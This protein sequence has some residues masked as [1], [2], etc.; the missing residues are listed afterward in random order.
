VIR[1]Q[2]ADGVTNVPF[3]Q[4]DV[5]RVRELAH[6][7]FPL[8]ALHHEIHGVQHVETKEVDTTSLVSR[9]TLCGIL[10]NYP[11]MALDQLLPAL[12]KWKAVLY[13]YWGGR[14]QPLS[15]FLGLKG[16]IYGT[17]RQETADV[18]VLRFVS[19]AAPSVRDRLVYMQDLERLA[20]DNLVE[21]PTEE[22]G[23]LKN[24]FE[25]QQASHTERRLAWRRARSADELVA[26]SVRLRL[27]L[28]FQHDLGLFVLVLPSAM[29][30]EELSGHIFRVAGDLL[31]DSP[32][33]LHY[34]LYYEIED[35]EAGESVLG[36]DKTV[37]QVVRVMGSSGSL[38]AKL[39]F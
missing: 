13:G 32:Q 29:T 36:L 38:T 24:A 25:A 20:W 15:H 3:G 26:G 5:E 1:H 21:I 11:L 4:E 19:F 37:G 31:D 12:A 10:L 7:L 16:T 34:W 6:H 30:L 18:P 2:L 23:T 8:R 22:I 28:A 35:D 17:V 33:P 39:A 9:V 27:S 14:K